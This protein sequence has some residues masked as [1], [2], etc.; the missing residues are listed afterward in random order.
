MYNYTHEQIRIDF[1][2]DFFFQFV[3][4]HRTFMGEVKKC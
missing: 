2:R 4:L 1:G 3:W